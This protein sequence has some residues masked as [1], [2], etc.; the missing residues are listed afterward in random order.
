[1]SAMSGAMGAMSSKETGE[2]QAKTAKRVSR[3]TLAA[4]REAIAFQKEMNAQAR[5]DTAPWREAGGKALTDLQLKIAE[6]PGDFES[7]P[8][9]EF[10]LAEGQKAIERGAAARGNLLGGAEQK[11]LLKYGQ[12]FAT[13]DY[14][15]FLRRHYESLT[16]LQ[17]LAGVGQSTA[18]QTAGQ[19]AN[20]GSNVGN[21]LL[22]GQNTAGGLQVAAGN[23]IAAGN[24]NAMNSI[25]GAGQSNVN[26]AM[27][28]FDQWKNRPA[29]N[30]AAQNVVSSYSSGGGLTTT[31]S[32]FNPSDLAR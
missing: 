32:S 29:T 1:M 3:D 14:D 9:Y 20:L 28:L 25:T 26:N 11:A 7:S 24:I 12:N 31:G 23:A 22:S 18:S 27:A 15:N 13:N 30:A 17:S 19:S 2:E 6:G 8:G 21:T 5:A 16:P 10:R 4:T